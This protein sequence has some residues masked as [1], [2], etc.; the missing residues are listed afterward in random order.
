MP[1]RRRYR[2][3]HP[4]SF[5]ETIVYLAFGLLLFACIVVYLQGAWSQPGALNFFPKTAVPTGIAVETARTT[6]EI[7]PLLPFALCAIFGSVTGLFIMGIIWLRNRNRFRPITKSVMPSLPLVN[8]ASPSPAPSQPQAE[9]VNRAAEKI[10]PPVETIVAE[11]PKPPLGIKPRSPLTPAEQ[12]FFHTLKA[13]VAHDYQVLA[14]VPLKQLVS[15]ENRVPP[16]V[17]G[18]LE[19]GTVDFVLVHPKYLGTVLAIELD[20][21]SHRQVISRSRDELKELILREARIPL[22][23]FRVG[24]QWNTREI[25]KRI[26]EIVEQNQDNQA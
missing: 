25:R 19:N 18:M 5:T 14:Q 6:V 26:N 23:R 9:S 20:D 1:R 22:L 8:S 12:A 15:R 24:E 21:S 13:A 11:S 10:I 17:Y 3:A 4:E 2:E 16:D 7:S